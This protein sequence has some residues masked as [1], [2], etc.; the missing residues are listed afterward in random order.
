MCFFQ[1]HICAEGTP[2]VTQGFYVKQHPESYRL[3]INIVLVGHSCLI[4]NST[5]KLCRKLCPSCTRLSFPGKS[6]TCFVGRFPR[7]SP[8][9][10]L[11]P[12][13]AAFIFRLAPSMQVSFSIWAIDA[14]VI[15]RSGH[16]SNHRFAIGPI[17]LSVLGPK[18]H[19]VLEALKVL[20]SPK[21][22]YGPWALK[23]LRLG[24]DVSVIC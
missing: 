7:R 23:T 19:M 12:I 24:G 17:S 5:N 13:D 6:L 18:T 10:R 4:K 9:F 16:R 8:Q 11:G 14:A 3:L 15:F 20:K 22:Y 2:L 1:Q 21:S